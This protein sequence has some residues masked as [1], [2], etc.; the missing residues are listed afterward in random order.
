M[1]AHLVSVGRVLWQWTKVQ[2][3][4]LSI[5]FKKVS[6]SSP[7]LTSWLIQLSNII[8]H[9]VFLR[10]DKLGIQ[11]D[12]WHL[13][14]PE[15]KYSEWCF[16]YVWDIT[17]NQT[18]HARSRRIFWNENAAFLLVTLICHSFFVPLC[19]A[20]KLCQTLAHLLTWVN[21][22]TSVIF[23][24]PSLEVLIVWFLEVRHEFTNG[25]NYC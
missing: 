4:L 14:L 20:T 19:P 23:S 25:W 10:E 11:I 21:T 15:S 6:C 3:G 13:F 24:S 1:I 2:N 8:C 5:V 7:C 12:L 9:C 22:W 17:A 16:P 18:W